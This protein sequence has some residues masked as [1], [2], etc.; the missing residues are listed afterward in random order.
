MKHYRGWKKEFYN[1]KIVNKNFFQFTNICS[2]N[3]VDVCPLEDSHVQEENENE[4]LF[5]VDRL[6]IKKNIFRVSKRI[7]FIRS[8]SE[9]SSIDGSSESLNNDSLLNE[10]NES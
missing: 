10:E 8:D 7:L 4:M 3:D 1:N 5:N 6:S 9:I 2:Y